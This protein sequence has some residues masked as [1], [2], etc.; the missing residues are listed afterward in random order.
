MQIVSP[1]R[2][3]WQYAIAAVLQDLAQQPRWPGAGDLRSWQRQR[4]RYVALYRRR[5][6]ALRP[7]EAQRPEQARVTRSRGFAPETMTVRAINNTCQTEAGEFAPS[8][9]NKFQIISRVTR[10]SALTRRV[11]SYQCSYHHMHTFE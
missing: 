9:V 8:D 2:R 7:G 10:V 6:E 5:L 11:H 3:V 1:R 4:R